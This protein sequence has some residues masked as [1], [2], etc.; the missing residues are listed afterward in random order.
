[1]DKRPEKRINN[2]Q[3]PACRSAVSGLRYSFILFL[4]C[5]TKEATTNEEASRPNIIIIFTDDQGYQDLGCYGS[6]DIHTPNLDKMAAEG[7]RFTRFYDAQPV[8]SASRAGLLTGCYPNRI[9]IHGALGPGAKA[10]LSH[11]EI[12]IAELVKPLGYSTAM[13]GKWH[14]GDTKEY[15][16][17]SHG[18]DEFFGL[19]YSN[20]MWPKHP[21]NPEA[22]PRLP[23][24]EGD[25]VAQYLDD[26]QNMLTTWYTE[27]AVDFIDRHKDKP[28][29]LYVAH[30][31]PHVP[32]FVSDKFRGSSPRGLYGDVIAEIDWSYRQINEALKRNGLEQNT[33]IIFTSD[34]GPWLSYG[35][36]SG[37]ALPLREGKGTVWEGGVRVPCIVK[38]PGVAPA[39]IVQN[40]PA[41]T[42]DILPTIAEL[43]QVDLPAKTIDGKSVL[44]LIKNETGTS[45]PHDAYYFYYNRNE[46]Q[47]L[48]SGDGK[49]KLYFPHK[50]RSLEDRPGRNDGIPIKYNNQVE[51]GLELYDLENDISE[52]TD[53]ADRYPEIV[54]QL[55]VL[56]DSCR[57]ELGD[58]LTGVAGRG[59]R[60]PGKL[61][62][63]D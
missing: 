31:M 17:K 61:I 62:T 43:L 63:N 53:L 15:L 41:M 26:D 19:P 42:I 55:S 35:T 48:M 9:G 56:A 24:I 1:M 27:R 30:S 20:D 4:S 44:S 22:W 59:N 32:L 54:R 10:V 5:G 25:S 11:D 28:F 46:L 45:N 29:F 23:L 12:T 18:F 13:F 39:G 33:L 14:L 49:W 34:N 38:W 36:H 6:P 3:I 60:E 51:T 37:S 8:C 57:A 50:Y 2:E 21:E 7:M 47:S 40:T 16:P 52:T 58:A